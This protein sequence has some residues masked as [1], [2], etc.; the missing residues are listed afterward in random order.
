MRLVAGKIMA[1]TRIDS[2]GLFDSVSQE[3]LE[4]SSA[5]RNNRIEYHSVAFLFFPGHKCLF[6]PLYTCHSFDFFFLV[7]HTQ[8][9]DI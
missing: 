7:F 1:M 3:K 4:F 6:M 9:L 2:Y 8:L 5:E